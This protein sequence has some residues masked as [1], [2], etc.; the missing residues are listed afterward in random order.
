[1]TD[2]PLGG[3]DMNIRHQKSAITCSPVPV[4][5][6]EEDGPHIIFGAPSERGRTICSHPESMRN[7]AGVCYCGKT[8]TMTEFPQV[9]DITRY[10]YQPGDKIIVN[11]AEPVRHDAAHQLREHISKALAVPFEDVIIV[12][13][14]IHISILDLL[15]EHADC[16]IECP[17]VE[18]ACPDD[19]RCGCPERWAAVPGQPHK[20]DG[21]ITS[22]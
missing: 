17:H 1:M 18:P 10:Q 21:T 19:C 12:D 20:V 22:A 16:G 11:C 8:I 3:E 9:S 5:V 14:G 15:T 7:P 6:V 4:L 2:S 13:A